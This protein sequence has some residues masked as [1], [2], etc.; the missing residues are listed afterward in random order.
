VPRQQVGRHAFIFGITERCLTLS[1]I[2]KLLY[3]VLVTVILFS[4][5]DAAKKDP[6]T[7]IEV[8]TVFIRAVLNNDFKIAEKYLLVDELNLQYF[9]S[10]QQQYQSNDKA[11]LE[12]YKTAV[13]NIYEIKS[14]S[15]SVHVVDFN[16][17]YKSEVK[18][19]LKLVWVNGKWLIDLKYTFT[20]TN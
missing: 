4:C 18:K 3:A 17:S 2:K 13:I 9:K 7:D 1:M 11:E 20:E 16:N 19:K 8:A 5:S 12:K 14:E 10:Y 6:V 15:D